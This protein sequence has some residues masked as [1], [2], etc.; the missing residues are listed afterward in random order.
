MKGKAE[1]TVRRI[2]ELALLSNKPGRARRESAHEAGFAI[3]KNLGRCGGRV[4][5]GRTI[6]SLLAGDTD[7]DSAVDAIVS[8]WLRRTVAA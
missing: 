3:A 7:M 2:L 1:N 4:A 6:D 8:A 5:C